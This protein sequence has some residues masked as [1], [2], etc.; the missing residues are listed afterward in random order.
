M[1]QNIYNLR[2]FE[3]PIVIWT[4]G[5]FSP[6]T[7]GHIEVARIVA[8]YILKLYPSSNVFLYFVPVSKN[9]SKNSVKNNSIG[10]DSDGIRLEMLSMATDHLNKTEVSGKIK[11]SVS[12]LEIEQA[13][14]VPTYE[15]IE[16]LKSKIR[17]N[18]RKDIPDSSFFISLGQDNVEGIISGKWAMPFTLLSKNIICVPRPLT[19]ANQTANTSRQL[20][21]KINIENMLIKENITPIPT[22][23]QL[24]SKI[25][26]VNESIPD[27]IVNT[28]ST[29]L[30]SKLQEYYKTREHGFISELKTM[31]LPEIIDLIIKN[32]YYNK[33]LMTGGFISKRK[34][35]L[36]QL[37][38]KTHKKKTHKL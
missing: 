33:K 1:A 32:N 8:T 36:K 23:D 16:M 6:P 22:I 17:E 4:G 19:D 24:I 20:I 21:S 34:S 35:K 29:K 28:S 25:L 3:N 30:R 7:S 12:N 31:T 18:S 37:R 15:S 2:D 38:K 10:G 13:R 5:S 26:I 11:Y 27:A 14:S 9:Y